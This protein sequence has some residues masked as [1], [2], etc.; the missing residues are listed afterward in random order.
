MPMSKLSSSDLVLFLDFDGPLHPDAVFRTRHAMELRAPGQLFMHAPLLVEILKVF[1]E[2]KISLSTSWS[3][4][5]GF[6]RARACLPTELQTRTVSSTWHS[7]MPRWPLQGYDTATRFEQIGAAVRTA[8]L[9]RWVAL[10]DD[11]LSSWPDTG[12]EREHLVL[13]DSVAGLAEPRIQQEL[14]QKLQAL[15]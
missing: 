12:P 5:L 9:T 15:R 8:G 1:P 3:R 7:R 4:T 14:T 10:D 11:P 13:C 6:R 2:V